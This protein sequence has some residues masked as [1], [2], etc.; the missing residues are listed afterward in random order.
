MIEHIYQHVNLFIQIKLLRILKDP[1]NYS[2]I[3]LK[4]FDPI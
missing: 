2:F 4:A 3:Y 1:L